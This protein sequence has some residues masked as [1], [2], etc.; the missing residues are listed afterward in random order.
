MSAKGPV[1][2]A[3]V[4]DGGANRASR[5]TTDA[6][7]VEQLTAAGFGLRL[8]DDEGRVRDALGAAAAPVT[9][10]LAPGHTTVE[11]DAAR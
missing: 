3:P 11:T 7:A 4:Q 10:P 8:L 5:F 9:P 1:C 6:A 2:Q